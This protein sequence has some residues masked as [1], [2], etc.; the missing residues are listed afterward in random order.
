MHAAEQ[1]QLL[2]ADN[3]FKLNSNKQCWKTFV[4]CM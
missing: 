1:N 3:L 2:W 4:F